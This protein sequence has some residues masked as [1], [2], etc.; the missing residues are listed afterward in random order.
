M[1]VDGWRRRRVR[2]PERTNEGRRN[3]GVKR[4]GKRRWTKSRE[5]RRAKDRRDVGVCQRTEKEKRG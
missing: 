4:R 2:E 5:A 1:N 3:K